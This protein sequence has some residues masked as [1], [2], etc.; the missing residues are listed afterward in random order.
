MGAKE[1]LFVYLGEEHVIEIYA[2]VRG[3][4]FAQLAYVRL[5]AHAE[6]ESHLTR[7]LAQVHH[8][9]VHVLSPLARSVHPPIKNQSINQQLTNMHNKAKMGNKIT[10]AF[11]WVEKRREM[12]RKWSS[13]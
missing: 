2:R 9:D 8:V 6:A 4:N 12:G 13:V 5:S 1:S 3:K 7:L 11:T 10:I